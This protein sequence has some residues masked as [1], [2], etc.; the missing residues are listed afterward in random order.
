MATG[1]PRFL[2][3]FSPTPGEGCCLCATLKTALYILGSL[4]CIASIAFIINALS[5]GLSGGGRFLDADMTL[6]ALPF[7]IMGMQ[8]MSRSDVDKLHYYSVFKQIQAIATIINSVLIMFACGD[9][10]TQ[11]AAAGVLGNMWAWYLAYVVW[12][13]EVQVAEGKGLLAQYGRHTAAEMGMGKRGA[14]VAYAPPMPM[15]GMSNA[16]I[17]LT[18]S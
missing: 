4:D 6:C 15:Q 18:D 9:Y 8:G 17:K 14:P 12:S 5:L 3:F 13:A 7:A 10:C 1:R 16:P 11:Y 2:L